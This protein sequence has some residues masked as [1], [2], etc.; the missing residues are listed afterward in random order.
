MLPAGG[1]SPSDARLLAAVA[2]LTLLVGA[3]LFALPPAAE[4]PLP[5]QVGAAA[6]A[7][8]VWSYCDGF[9]GRWVQVEGRTE[10]VS[11]PAAM[12]GLVDYYRRLS[13]EHENWDDYRASM[14][15]EQRV[16]LRIEL[17]RA[18]PDRAG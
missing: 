1:P 10:I 9:F 13:G 3:A 2:G 18:G 4:P 12:D 5:R 6:A 15:R 16:L 14:E 17:T 7:M 11:L 8:V